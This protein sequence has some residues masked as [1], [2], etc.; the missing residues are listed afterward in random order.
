MS[1]ALT[2]RELG[3][4]VVGELLGEGGMG[5]VFA[6]HHRFLGTKVAI[7]VLHGTF[8]NDAAAT[9]RF[10]QEAK[11]SLEIGH[12]NVIK[13]L[14]FGQSQEGSLYLVM[15]LLDGLSL[16]DALAANGPF[17][18]TDAVRIG[19][20]IC[21]ALAAAHAKG[22][23]HR[24][25]KPDNV[26]LPRDGGVKVLDFGIAKVQSTSST[27]TGALLGT[28]IYMA[29][30]QCRDAKLVGPHTDVY[31]M[32]VMLFEM[33]TGQPPFYGGLHEVLAKHLFEAPP[34]PSMLVNV[35]PELEA[36]IMQCLEKQPEDRPASM[37][38]VRDRLRRLTTQT[39]SIQPGA[40]PAVE[41][42][43]ASTLSRAAGEA[44]PVAQPPRKSGVLIGGALVVL[45]LAGG[46]AALFRHSSPPTEHPTVAAPP[47]PVAPAPKPVEV[48]PPPTQKAPE[49]VQAV[50]RS[51]PAGATVTVD[52][53]VVGTTPA[54]VKLVPPKEI[55]LQRDGYQPA[56]EIVTSAGELDITLIAIARK[57]P[58]HE[59]GHPTPQPRPATPTA[60]AKSN[61]VEGLD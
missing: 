50:V 1:Q 22:I 7:K 21:D 4:Y 25:L 60:P 51:Q 3:N 39:V 28:P 45:A 24:D 46:A 34:K 14:D 19:S 42:P 57:R 41:P 43:T 58:G 31:A 35:S 53:A 30:E 32:G 33:V 23:T 5:A 20:A 11:A 56:R 37:S 8:A 48:P 17:S 2:G 55:I 12:P 36:L 6:G 49:P 27:Q 54:L 38:A 15:E 29:P 61:P 10:F 16:K 40:A 47:R 9:Q 26:Y 52:G 59:H 18:E 44:V 13:I